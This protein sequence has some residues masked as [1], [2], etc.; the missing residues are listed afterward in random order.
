[1][2]TGHWTAAAVAVLLMQAGAPLPANASA[3]RVERHSTVALSFREGEG[4]R[5]DVVAVAPRPG[6]IGRADIKRHEGRTRIKL[7]VD[8]SLKNPQ[9]LGPAYTA[10]VLW[11][12]A[13]EG[14]A[15]NL[16]ELP[17]ARHFD[18]DATTSLD[19][20]GLIVTAEPYSAV[21]RP[22][23]MLV[24]QGGVRE[25]TRAPVRPAT[26]E[27]V[28]TPE[29]VGASVRAD[30]KT[31]LLLLGARRAV[32][33]ARDA[34]APQYASSE[35]REAEG[36]LS[37]LEQISHGKKELSR[38]AQ[39]I[40]RD[41]MRAADHARVVALDRADEAAR[42]AERSAAQRAVGRAEAQADRAQAEADE[43]RARAERD[44]QQA[45]EARQTAESQRQQADEA[46][47]AAESE[48][49]RAD[50]AREAAERAEQEVEKARTSLQQAQTD[51]ERAQANEE[52]ARAEA[53]RAKAEAQQARQDKQEME[54]RLY[55]SL[56]EILETRREAR[57]LIV[58]LSDV[59]FDFD[60][61]T[62]T[63]GAREKLSRLAG[64]LL[65]Y[66]GGYDM[67]V[68]GHTDSVGTHDYNQ[69][70]SEDRARSVASYLREAGIPAA[71][72]RGVQGFAETRPVA[73]N[74]NAAGRQRNRRVELV[75]GGL[76]G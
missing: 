27:Y 73:T 24:A 32:E 5:V 75:I 52:L 47:Q 29:P 46:R 51:A 63:P 57:G 3:D 21:S 2:N 19:T 15:E 54:T 67:Q 64:I 34:G 14:R 36:K 44:R 22:G 45:L 60:R 69:R 4:T 74:D 37:A 33:M 17:V 9:T 10:Y 20:F 38:D 72:I 23:P 55:R 56:S 70:L 1:M 58:S 12:V 28:V 68:E 48:R 39:G 43:A 35:L 49:K 7:D 25:D 30:L 61:A 42:T 16:A 66:Q 62:L 8:K 41:V 6:R 13:P 18:L 40:A 53:D 76:E 50:E 59:L 11:A 31:P 65:A 26:L 71:R